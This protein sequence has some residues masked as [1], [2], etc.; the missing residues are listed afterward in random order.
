MYSSDFSLS[1]R[2]FMRLQKYEL[3]K[4]E[5]TIGILGS[6]FASRHIKIIIYS[7]T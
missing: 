5:K 4:S 6:G 1:K 7:G 2:R 3:A